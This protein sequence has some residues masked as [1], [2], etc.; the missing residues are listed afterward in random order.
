MRVLAVDTTSARGSVAVVEGD[1]ILAELRISSATG[2]S[3]RLLPGIAFLLDSLGLAPTD[4]DGF[5][6]TSGPGSFTALRVGIATVQ[7]LALASARPGLGVSALDVLAARV[8]G[9]AD[10]IVSLMNAYRGDAFAAFYDREG[11]PR[12]PAVIAS[13]AQIVERSPAG[14]AFVGDGVELHRET[15]LAGVRGAIFSGRSLFLAGTL[16]RLAT[17]RFAAGEGGS[18]DQLRP[19][20]IREADIRGTP[21]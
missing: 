17:R 9:S 21:A 11:R 14:A 4:L 13:P 19:F 10:T 1:D 5:A 6:V 2:H 12:G 15:I 16:G 20:Y 3:T 8:V 7:G 18:P